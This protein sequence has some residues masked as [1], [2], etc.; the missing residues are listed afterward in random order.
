MIGP[1]NAKSGKKYKIVKRHLGTIQLR[2]EWL[3]SNYTK[4]FD[5]KP[6]YANWAKLT[7]DNFCTFDNLWT[8]S[9]HSNVLITSVV[10]IATSYNPSNGI[11]T[12]VFYWGEINGGGKGCDYP[13]RIITMEEA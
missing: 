6:Y 5:V 9:M 3:T 2:G 11:L 13:I 12:A 8:S 1:T 10:N 7:I 4:T